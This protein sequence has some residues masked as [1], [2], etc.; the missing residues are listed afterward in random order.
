M[1]VVHITPTY[2]DDSSI[3][4]GGERYP[5][6]LASWMAKMVPTTLV[7]FSQARRSFKQGLLN[8]EVFPV[9]HLLSGNKVNPL[10]FR[11]LNTLFRADIVHTHQVFTMVSDLGC[12]F[13]TLLGKRRFV[14]DY[15]GG[16]GRVLNTK[17]PILPLYHGAIAYSEFGRKML[18]EVL[19]NKTT[20]IKGGIDSD[21]FCPDS[22]VPKQK[23]I[24]YV[25]RLLPHKGANYLIE[26]F[27]LLK[28]Q[29]YRLRLV[30]RPYDGRFLKDLHALSEGLPV[31][32]VHDANDDDLL[33][34]YR[35]AQVTVLPSVHR[36]CYGDISSVPELMGFTLLE[37]QA[38]GTP[39]ICTT[40]GAMHEFVEDGRTG[41]V[42]KENSPESLCAALKRIVEQ[43]DADRAAMS[44]R[45]REFMQ[46]MSWSTV[47]EKHLHLYAAQ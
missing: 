28:R 14:T 30:G 1:H 20:L 25:G 21:R 39:A 17:L 2:F 24:L 41:F 40:A 23:Q 11:F 16:G 12:L 8:I 33:H 19:R 44:A 15:G 3:I 43:S 13:A 45:C 18:P 42:V 7:T 38:C 26:A 34:E 31:D 47:V 46:P 4:G 5:S 29:D 36:N 10:S 9:R 32:F 35:S 6:E 22:L 27:R 37:S